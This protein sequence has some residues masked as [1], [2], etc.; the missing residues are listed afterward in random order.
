V[1]LLKPPSED[2][3]LPDERFAPLDDRGVGLGASALKRGIEQLVK[4]PEVQAQVA[5]E[6]GNPDLIEEYQHRQAEQVSREFMRR[7]PAYHRCEENHEALVQTLAFNAFGWH[8]DEADVD[9]AQEEL[10]R[11]GFWT[12]E[13][14]T[15]AYNALS[16]AGALQVR[17]DQP[18][19]LT[20]RDLRAIALQAGAGDIE[21]AISRY[22]LLRAPADTKELF[23]S[24][25]TMADALDEI[26][27]PAIADIV[28][29]AVW[30]CWQQGRAEYSPSADRRSFLQSYIAGR[31]P[32]VRLLDEA[33]AACQAEEK[34]GMRAS[35]FRQLDE[36]AT[37]SDTPD[38][39][40][41]DD[42]EV[43]RLYHSTLRKV[44][45]RD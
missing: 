13:N 34:S 30:F 3:Q 5:Y 40:A 37:G 27:D 36:G 1:S 28:S 22:L 16:R 6:T 19:K 17:P 32:T 20:E 39:E 10:I 15:A 26:A 33:W 12:T 8:E 35:L 44:R 45:S 18:R 38:L 21:G 31:I 41:L 9:E 4:D 11:R 29:E 24:A 7:N 43:D 23:L 42:D 14:L 25:P 2:S